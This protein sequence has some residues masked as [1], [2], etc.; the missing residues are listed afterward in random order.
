MKLPP[1]RRSLPCR[2]T[3]LMRNRAFPRTLL[4]YSRH[5]PRPCGGPRGVLFLA[6]E[7]TLQARASPRRAM[8]G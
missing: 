2:G 3:S 7:V 4:M 5:M 1:S 6:S 8:R